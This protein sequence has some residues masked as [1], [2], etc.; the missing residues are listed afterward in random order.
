MIATPPEGKLVDGT[1]E[2]RLPARV[3]QDD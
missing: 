2:G 1:H 3:A